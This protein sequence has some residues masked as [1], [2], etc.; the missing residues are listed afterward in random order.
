MS[1]R[2]DEIRSA[3]ERVA[4]SHG[5][6]VVDMEFA[7]PARERTLRVFLEKNAEG[8]AKLKAE[9]ASGAE[10]LPERLMEGR[11]SGNSRLNTDQL[12]GVTH[13]DCAAFSRDFGVLLDVEDL[14]PGASYT[15]E[16]SS[17]GLDRKLTHPEDFERFKGCLVKVQTFEPVRNNRHWQGRLVGVSTGV[18]DSPVPKSEGP[19]A[20]S[21]EEVNS[22]VSESRTGAPTITID[23]S[24]TKQNSKSRKAGVSKVEIALSNIEKAQLVP[25]I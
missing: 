18:S 2:L 6:A 13:E 9:I 10:G 4:A 15:L 20:P 8:R 1:V 12:S 24:A 14:V 11:L 22:Q 16:A 3:A 7:G 21:S 17:P 19:G 5:L 25:E 23:L